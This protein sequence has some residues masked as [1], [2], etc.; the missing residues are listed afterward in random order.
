[1]TALP[2]IIRE[3]KIVSGKDQIPYVKERLLAMATGLAGNGN[4]TYFEGKNLL[5]YLIF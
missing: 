1:M 5:G 3:A 4:N 2:D